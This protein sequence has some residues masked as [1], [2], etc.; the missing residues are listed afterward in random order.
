MGSELNTYNFSEGDFAAFKAH[1]EQETR[2]LK[3]YFNDGVFHSEHPV[4]GFE[5]EAWIVDKDARP[6]AQNERFLA[7]I[8]S[9]DVVPEL[10]QFNFEINVPPHTLRKDALSRFE[11]DLLVIWQKCLRTANNL[12]YSTM[13]IGIHPCIRDYQ[14]SLINLSEIPRCR[15]LNE[16]ILAQRQGKPLRLHIEGAETLDIVKHDVVVGAAATSFQ[17]HLKV[18][19]EQ[20]ARAHNISQIISAPLLAVSANSPYAFD[21]E[22]WDETRIPL[23]ERSMHTGDNSNKRIHF[24]RAYIKQS[25]FELFEINAREF[26]VL[27]PEAL[28]DGRPL[29]H[30]RMHNG[31]VWRWNRPLIGFNDDGSF[32]LRIEN[33]VVSAGPTMVDCVANAAFYWGLVEAYLHIQPELEK[34]IPFNFAKKNFYVCAEHSLHSKLEWTHGRAVS[35]T[36]LI[37]R[38]L[39]PLAHAGL[40]RL[41]LDEEEILHYLAIIEGR[42]LRQQN[43]AIWQ[44]NWIAKHGRDMQELSLAYLEQ[45]HT[46]KPV[47]LWKV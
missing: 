17:I 15:A 25:L 19:Q 23:S 30:L 7:N 29:P 34:N 36:D 12:G 10:S 37:L 44:K 35:C 32:H 2:E 14:L 27:L 9:K 11:R 18:K 46:Q 1:V 8:N 3:N 13:T 47:H 21:V 45:Q 31:T 33:R 5:L 28:S 4:G 40:L 39:L 6:V 26:P 20:A 22:L 42:V 43:G 38:E 16:Q 24:G 41:G